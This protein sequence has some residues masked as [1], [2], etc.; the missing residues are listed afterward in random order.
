MIQEHDYNNILGYFHRMADL[1]AKE[2]EVRDYII[3]GM[4]YYITIGYFRFYAYVCV[5]CVS[6]Q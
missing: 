2:T 3:A 4:V 5:L 6:V 1:R